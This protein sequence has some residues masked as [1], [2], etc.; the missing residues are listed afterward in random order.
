MEAT[1][2]LLRALFKDIQTSSGRQRPLPGQSLL[3]AADWALLG[4]NEAAQ[5]PGP[6]S[7]SLPITPIPLLTL[8]LSTESR[9]RSS[10][11]CRA[12]RE[13]PGTRQSS[14]SCSSPGP[15]ATAVPGAGS[16]RE[17]GHEENTW[18]EQSERR[19]LRSS[20]YRTTLTCR[21]WGNPCL[22]LNWK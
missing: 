12:G 14:P 1:L 7:S 2:H 19:R 22:S 9:N 16:G 18:D 6:Q 10:V 20:S 13:S 4:E 21:S 15:G 11:S 17:Q 3:S 8:N 5:G